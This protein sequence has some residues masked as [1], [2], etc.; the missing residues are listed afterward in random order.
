MGPAAISSRKSVMCQSHF[1][2]GWAQTYNIPP[3]TSYKY[4]KG[5]GT[6]PFFFGNFIP[7][8]NNQMSKNS[9]RSNSSSGSSQK[10]SQRDVTDLS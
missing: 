3:C 9:S 7:A 8:C 1:I 6:P 5:G 2:L 10:V 4:D